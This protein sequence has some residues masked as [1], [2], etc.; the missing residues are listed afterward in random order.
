MRRI[1]SVLPRVLA[2]HQ[3]T[4][5]LREFEVLAKWSQAVGETVASHA[6]AVDIRR[7]RL[8]VRVDH[9]VWSHHLSL[10]K[11]SLMA[12][13]NDAVGSRVVSDIRFSV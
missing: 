5:R 9:P 1:G 7:G 12:K 6:S 8:V 4:G 3:L 13:L 11:P 10:L 2:S